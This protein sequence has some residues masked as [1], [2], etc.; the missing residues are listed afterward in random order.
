MTALN[1][2]LPRLRAS[3]MDVDAHIW[4]ETEL[5]E[6]FTQSLADVC[7]YAGQPYG[8][9]GLNDPVTLPLPELFVPLV[10]RGAVSYALL[11]RALERLDAY[12]IN[13]GL[14][15]QALQASTEVWQRFEAGLAALAGIRVNALQM[16]AEPPY[17]TA[18]G[19]QL[20][21]APVFE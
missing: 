8:V 20:P 1:D 14:P 21:T 2:L 18:E 5:K 9:T 17:P 19:W 4:Q 3:L 13:S 12:N 15:A 10:L 16:A 6:A 7:R 11:W